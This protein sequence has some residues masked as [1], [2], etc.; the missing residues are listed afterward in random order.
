[1]RRTF[2]L[3]PQ[4]ALPALV[5]PRS[6]AGTSV[7]ARI[8]TTSRQWRASSETNHTRR[9][10]ALLGLK[11]ENQRRRHSTRSSVHHRRACLMIEQFEDRCLLSSLEL[12]IAESGGPAITILDNGA[13]DTDPTI[14]VINVDTSEASGINLL[15]VNYQFTQLGANSNSP[16]SS[17]TGIVTQ[18]GVAQL[19][20]GGTGSVTVLASDG[21]Y[22]LPNIPLG[23]MHS[24]ASNTYFNATAGDTS[25]FQSWF[26]PSNGLGGKEVASPLVTLTSSAANPNSQSA[27]AAPTPVTL[28]TPYA[29]TNQMVITLTGGDP[30]APAQ[31]QY[32]GS[33]TVTR[34][35]RTVVDT[36][37]DEDNGNYS[38]GDL[39]L[40]EAITLANANPGA[41]SISFAIPGA[42]VHT[43][44]LLSAL[45]TITDPVIIDGYSQPGASPNTLAVG[46]NAL[47]LIE[48]N[49]ANAGVGVTGLMITA[50]S[51]TVRGLVINRFGGSGIQVDSSQ[52]L[53]TGNFIGTDVNGTAA[54]GNGFDG[55]LSFSS[56]NTIGGTTVGARN[57]ISGN[58]NDGVLISG[59]SNN[60]VL[61]NFIGVGADG[62]TPLGNVF[63]G[64]GLN[65][66]SS[67][68]MIGNVVSD[69]GIDQDAAG[70]NLEANALNN[71]IAGN[72]IGTDVS[73]NK[74]L[75][76]SLHGIFLGNGSSNNTI[77]GLTDNDR[78][79]IS[80]NGKSP[81]TIRT[82]FSIVSIR[83]GV[84][85]YIFGGNGANT[86]GNVV[87][88][89]S[90]GTNVE[91]TAALP[92]SVIGVLISQSS[93]N[94]V[95]GN[96][97]SGNAFIGLEIAGG[98]ASGNQ[99]QGN[100]I[101]TNFD[102]TAAIPNGLDGILINNAPNN[103]IG[104]TTA[105]AGNLISGNRSVGIQ[106]F[107]PLTVG[108]VIEGN[109]LGLDSAGR[110][111]L[112]NRAGGI[113]VNTG[114]LSNQIGG[115]APGQANDGQV[116]PRFSISGFHQSRQ[117]L[118]PHPAGARHAAHSARPRRLVY[119]ARP[120][121][122]AD[123]PVANRHKTTL[124]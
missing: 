64:I 47:L 116:R 81:I 57:V 44:T 101:G 123:H 31:D 85:V 93:G 41:D 84:G 15:L 23:T 92:N 1:M 106:L 5:N 102:G 118:R 59:A 50:G 83:G 113:F 25:R 80:G 4:A 112:L 94:T 12:I 39:S 29:L 67:N 60:A 21:D 14:G 76:N 122:L 108:N 16:G 26:N 46:D 10:P 42:G 104:G 120:H 119:S 51:S 35:I 33:T 6:P 117:G 11:H 55:V 78:N 52:N 71:V 75:G 38:P 8:H 77:G 18:T 90:I 24:T 121:S 97:I 61:F 91:G 28:T 68:S 73:G 13:L 65:N 45:P 72:K 56:G 69:N 79:V 110:P 17:A 115:T 88:N 86:S 82:S 53:I 66:A 95:Q 107:G 49:G 40:R 74:T 30:S 114:P 105:G 70:I 32:T 89:N 58:G 22:S 43:I 100:K 7:S 3:S 54:L 34:G 124:R 111:T 2:S 98:T 99:V 19:L 103:T 96:L 48:L 9:G 27:D 37:S 36:T 62:T 63:D 109:A 20:P 87:L